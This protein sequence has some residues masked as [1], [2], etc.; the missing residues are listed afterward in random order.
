MPPASPARDFYGIQRRLVGSITVGIRHEEGLQ[1]PFQDLLRHHLSH[2]IRH[3]GHTPRELHI[4]PVDL[5]DRLKSSIRF[6]PYEDSG[7]SF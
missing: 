1:R 3:C 5:W 4:Y 6:I 2:T 7:S